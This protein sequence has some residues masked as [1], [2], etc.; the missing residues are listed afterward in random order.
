MKTRDEIE[1][2]LNKIEEMQSQISPL[3]YK[4]C[5]DIYNYL[6]E[7]LEDEEEVTFDDED[8]QPIDDNGNYIIKIKKTDNTIYYYT[9]ETLNYYLKYQSLDTLAPVYYAYLDV[10]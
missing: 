9:D 2:N 8:T 1:N 4:A 6:Y 7:H 10:K 3:V 5:A